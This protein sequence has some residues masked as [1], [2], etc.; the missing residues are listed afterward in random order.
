VEFEPMLQSVRLLV[1]C[2][3]L[4]AAPT[5]SAQQVAE[6]VALV[7]GNSDYKSAP[8]PNPRND[9]KA[10]GD[11]L[12][13]AGFSVDQ[14]VDT[15]QAD[16][17]DAIEK[18]GQVIRDPKVKFGLFYYAGH[19]LQLE[20]RNYLVPVSADIRTSDD[21]KKQTVDV[22]QLLAYMD[23]AKGRSFLVIL[24]ACRDDP[25]AGTY[26]PS[27]KGLSQF[28]AP[29]G[30]LLAYATAPGNV[31]LDGEGENGLYT[32]SLLQE[33]AAPGVKLEDAFK[34]VRLTV[35]LAS[36]GKQIPWE[37]TSL[38]EDVY[39]FPTTRR[40]LSDSEQEQQLD[41]ELE[42]WVRV[43]S[44]NNVEQVAG[45]LR[46]HPS[47]YVSELAQA[48]L[49]RLLAQQAQA[50]AARAPA[51]VVAVADTQ[52]REQVRQQQAD[53]EKKAREEAARLA[54]AEKKAREEAERLALAEQRAREE[55]AR[56]QA[57]AARIAREEDA[58]RQA[59]TARLAREEE[60]RRVAEAERRAREEAVRQAEAAR[61]AREAE[62]RRVAEA[63]RAAREEAERQARVAQAVREE[64]Q[65]VAQLEAAERQR[66]E[67]LA[68]QQAEAAEH[69]REQAQ[70]QQQIREEEQ[71]RLAE[72]ERRAQEEA[73][74]LAEAQRLVREEDARRLAEAERGRLEAQRIAAAER[75]A[76]EEA[77]RRQAE[78]E[79]AERARQEA[80]RQAEAAKAAREAEDR[81]IAELQRQQ[82]VALAATPPAAVEVQ[83]L[84]LSAT[85]FSAGYVEHDRKYQVGD[86]HQFRVVDAL[87]KIE[88]P[89]QLQVTAVDVADD[90]V[91]F[92]GGEYQSDL[93]GNITTN[94]RGTLSSPRQFYPAELFVGK[95]WQTMFKQVR[96]SGITYTFKYDVKVVG[97]EKITVPAGTFDA[98][99]IE[100]RGFNMQLG[101]TL[102]RNIWIAPGV[103]AD[104]AHETQV[105]LRNNVIEQ[106]ERQE[107]VALRKAGGT[108]QR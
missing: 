32:S 108:A 17:K 23:Q 43:K 5:L 35:R 56:K 87:T 71:R 88:K 22:S 83:P 77:A 15:S 19:G 73:R 38:E 69:A 29:V 65:R 12:R 89:F 84:T 25:F 11:L 85:P 47:G 59:E 34:R 91:D 75:T 106:Y 33:F 58:R 70:R 61:L 103:A 1:A 10:M 98:F 27:A 102:T 60:A 14:R 51:Q 28:D 68:R 4:L 107:L 76:R 82:Q 80:L 36:K 52:A 95:K 20:W 62:V 16:L 48:R 57:E 99:K 6:R 50:E 53:A 66:R 81:R 9:A 31:A 30:S 18:F 79:V 67:A 105:R 39:L 97:R 92:N 7:I 90:R 42:A 94:A 2:V 8:L 45:F 64:A 21:V 3:V 13:R 40:K 78:A 37:S 41:K 46:Q 63:E 104:I 72:A 100:A 101:A 96:P 93:M 44:S 86:V 54:E 24:D 26:R 55:H 74:R 49:S